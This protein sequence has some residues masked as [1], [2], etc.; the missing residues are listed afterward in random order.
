[1]GINVNIEVVRNVYFVLFKIGDFSVE[2]S[3][4]NFLVVLVL[5]F[6]MEFRYKVLSNDFNFLN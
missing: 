6:E 1:M 3:L 5:I 4:I 2:N